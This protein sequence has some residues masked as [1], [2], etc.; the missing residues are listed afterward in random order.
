MKLWML[1]AVDFDMQTEQLCVL[2]DVPSEARAFV[3]ATKC[4][5]SILAMH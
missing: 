1:A 3:V 4:S 2:K 5:T